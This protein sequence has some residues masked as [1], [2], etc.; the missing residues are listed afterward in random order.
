MLG[1]HLARKGTLQK[2]HV[3]V[4]HMPRL[5]RDIIEATVK[6]QPDMDLVDCDEAE[7]LALNLQNRAVDVAIVAEGAGLLER[8]LVANPGLKV[9]VVGPDGRAAEF[10]ELR[11]H[12]LIDPSPRT[13]VDAIHAALSAHA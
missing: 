6:S 8:L 3:L 4:T 1:R 5:L 9:V 11:R 7:R 2:A 10:V 13:L 12:S